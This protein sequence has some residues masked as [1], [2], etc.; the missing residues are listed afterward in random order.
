MSGTFTPHRANCF[1]T[2]LH[3]NQLN[4]REEEQRILD[5]YE[6]TQV[7]AS[8]SDSDGIQD[9]PYQATLEGLGSIE[10]KY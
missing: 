8:D 10:Y 6:P 4:Q 5:T 2:S 9:V 1:S 3:P 7:Q